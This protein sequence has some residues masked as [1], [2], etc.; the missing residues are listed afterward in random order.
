M[1]SKYEMSKAEAIETIAKIKA[2]I[3]EVE[4]FN[5][6]TTKK[7][8]HLTQLESVRRLLYKCMEINDIYDPEYNYQFRQ[9][10]QA[11]EFKKTK[12]ELDHYLRWCIEGLHHDLMRHI[13]TLETIEDDIAS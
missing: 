3:P 12:K 1:K 9:Y 4:H 13:D 8:F 11:I 6:T 7:V 2:I 10:K 5:I